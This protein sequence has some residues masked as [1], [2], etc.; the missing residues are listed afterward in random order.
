MKK[1]FVFLSSSLLILTSCVQSRELE[2]LGLTTAVG[3]DLAQDDLIS[4]TI[5]LENFN[6][7]IENSSRTVTAQSHTSKGMRQKLNLETSKNIV[8]GQLRV[9][10]YNEEL[11]SKGIYNLVDTL[12]RDPSIGNMIYLCVTDNTAKE[13]LNKKD[14]TNANSNIGTFLYNLIEQNYKGDFIPSPTL[15]NFLTRLWEVGRDPQLPVLSITDDF[16]GITSMG[17][18]E[19][20]KLVYLLPM[21]KIFYLNVL[22]E[23]MKSGNTEIGL[24]KGDL[25]KHF[26]KPAE[27]MERTQEGNIIFITLSHIQ[28][29]KDIKLKESEELTFMI[30][31]KLKV[32]IV[33]LSKSLEL[34]DP[35]TIEELT[36]VLNKKFKENLENTLYEIKETKSDPVGF[37]EVYRVMKDSKLTQEK[38]RELYPSSKF[39]VKVDTTIV[40]TGVID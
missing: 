21:D 4:S 6:P 38:W 5:V 34:G 30:S 40:Q 39:E 23:D 12:S 15:H 31:L 33:E 37:G 29:N 9:A 3:Y 17:L 18:F 35:K 7:Q 22:S 10:I 16:V 27:S 8:S 32:R 1:F 24:P 2:N 20:D 13:I 28:A 25:E 19:N 14:P 26:V 36:K 11:S